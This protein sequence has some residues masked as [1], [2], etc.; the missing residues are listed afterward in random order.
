M[1]STRTII[2]AYD[3]WTA[4]KRVA[5]AA[6]RDVKAMNAYALSEDDRSRM[7]NERTEA[8]NLARAEEFAAREALDGAID[9]ARVAVEA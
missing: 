4:A 6:E 2:D 3:R 5:D 7:Y 1:D 8:R 9:A